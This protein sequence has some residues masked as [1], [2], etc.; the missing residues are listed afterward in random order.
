MPALTDEEMAS[1]LDPALT[2]P[3]QALEEDDEAARSQLLENFQQNKFAHNANAF[4]ANG[5]DIS[6]QTEQNTQRTDE[7][8]AQEQTN[9]FDQEEASNDNAETHDAGHFHD[10]IERAVLEE[11]GSSHA[12]PEVPEEEVHAEEMVLDQGDQQ[13][14]DEL[15][16]KDQD[17]EFED[18]TSNIETA[19]IDAVTTETAQTAGDV[20]LEPA[21]ASEASNS[22]EAEDASDEEIDLCLFCNQ[23]EPE[24]KGTGE[25]VSCTVC[26]RPAHQACAGTTESSNEDLQS[27]T[28][29][30]C[31]QNRT[32]ESPKETANKP[33]HSASR[34]VRDLLPVSRGVQ[35]PG[36][37][38]IF[39]Q[40]LIQED[41]GGRALRRKR[42]S[43][44]TEPGTI[45]NKRRKTMERTP[46]PEKIEP[47]P[48]SHST[49]RSSQK[50]APELPP[51][52]T[53]RILQ[54]R[55][56]HK[57]P[58][59]KFILAFRLDQSKIET[60]LSEPP[61]PGRRKY[62]RKKQKIV[63]P[64][65]HQPPVPKFPALPTHHLIFPSMFGD[66]END[67]NAKPYGG[68]LSEADAETSRSLPQMRDREIFEIA[69][70]EAEEEREKTSAE[71]EAEINGLHGEGAN[72]TN[73]KRTVSGPPS[74]I[75]C[76][77]FGKHVIDTSYAA[78]YP[79]E[80]SHES[81]L[82]ICEFCLKYLPSEFV[83][84]RH[85]LKCPAKHP[86]GDEIYRDGSLSVWEVD[87]RKKTEYCQCLCLMAKLFL[88]SK[89]LYYDVDP[90]LFYVLTEYD[91][92][93]YHF[94]GYFSKEKRP[95][96]QN[97]VS[98]IL[99]MPIHQRKGYAT[100]LIEFSYLLT[101]IEGKEG[102]PEK[103]LSDM[104]LT[105]Y[106]SY[107]DLTISKHLLDLGNKP[108]SVKDIMAMTGMTADDVVHSL[109]RL[110]A[111]VKDPV[112]KTYAVRYD[113]NLYENIVDKYESKEFRKIR[114]ESLVWTPYI[115]G[116]SDA[117]TLDA[118]PITAVAQREELE[119]LENIEAEAEQQAEQQADPD[120]VSPKTS[121]G[122][123]RQ[124]PADAMID[125]ALLKDNGHIAPG[126]P[127][128]DAMDGVQNEPINVEPVEAMTNG[129]LDKGK[130][131]AN[132]SLSGYAL[133]YQVE[134]IPA[135]RFQIDP[136]I[137]PAMLR[138]AKS[139][140]KSMTGTP[141]VNGLRTP[142]GPTPKAIRSSPR[143]AG[144][145]NGSVGGRVSSRAPTP[146]KG[147]TS[148]RRSV[149][150]S[151]LAN[152]IV[153]DDG[154]GREEEEEVIED[155]EGQ[156]EEEGRDGDEE[157]DGHDDMAV[158]PPHGQEVDDQ[159]SEQGSDSEDESSDRSDESEGEEVVESDASDDPD[160]V[161][162]EDEDDEDDS[163][164][165]EE[166]AEVDIPS[167]ASSAGASD[168]EGS[169]GTE[170]D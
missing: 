14:N 33:R 19:A 58:P 39:A 102:S 93:G 170:E 163:N 5:A 24:E 15:E 80:Y 150:K 169:E 36:A 6:V 85:K 118:Q 66:R 114:P 100:F 158:Q 151:G 162:D 62:V 147:S 164:G 148:V 111:F 69:R 25:D 161:V 157:E 88:G 79:E 90:F 68:I 50:L 166:N 135:T 55:P 159:N 125:P 73:S 109:E 92:Y 84:W 32:S 53:A 155:G 22:S 45:M 113:K 120:N 99:V 78:P 56:F 165:E 145:V 91:D 83:A 37:H 57:Q 138:H 146:E 7:S 1:L 3:R 4:L 130:E 59:H 121:Q 106:R 107:W 29:P 8:S 17:E 133:T 65:V 76:I 126:P 48:I 124:S 89:T 154:S 132:D 119:E 94:V 103:P 16:S 42:K 149:R 38:S 123:S 49:R 104:G 140:R 51:V 20:E 131:P 52:P 137:P 112:T 35:K 44:S 34:L 74:K 40:P 10:Q 143:K 12:A 9:G 153:T 28:C 86:P 116:R 160:A 134:K 110:Y 75:K 71:A 47:E 64:P 26:R 142:K 87:G 128:V 108:F 72:A 70:K 129:L 96:S 2:A 139:K 27:W 54:H 13:N 77:Q 82:F 18:A 61:R 23:K 152:E 115:M 97:N 141:R 101:R 67:I 21:P 95:A 46:K 117:A 41:N 105:A 30:T 11:R 98:C 168:E 136:P 43:P 122:R 60:I 156:E 144:S 127:P 31:N 167:A 81:R 63:A